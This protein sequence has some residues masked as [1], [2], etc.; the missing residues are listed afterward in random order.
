MTKLPFVFQCR[1]VYVILFTNISQSTARQASLYALGIC[2]DTSDSVVITTVTSP[3]RCA[4]F[5]YISTQ[6]AGIC[7]FS[8]CQI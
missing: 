5:S 1:H 3:K 4:S 6:L 2:S 7:H 8:C